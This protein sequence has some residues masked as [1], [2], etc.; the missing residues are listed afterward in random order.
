MREVSS[1]NAIKA[2]LAVLCLIT[3]S[4]APAATN[5]GAPKWTFTSI[6]FPDASVTVAYDINEDGDIVGFY[7]NSTGFH[8]YLLSEGSFTTIDFP[9][10]IQTRAY[11]INSKDYIVGLYEDSTGFHGFLLREGAFTS[12]D[13]PNSTYTEA[14]EINSRGDITGDYDDA[15]FKTRAFLLTK[16]GS[17][18]SLD[19]PFDFQAS[20]THGLTPNNKTIVG[21]WF[22]DEWVMHSLIL[23]GDEYITNDFPDSVTS[24][25]WRVNASGQMVGRYMDSAGKSHG[26]LYSK[27]THT[28]IDF[29][30]A[31]FTDACGINASG[32]IVGLYNSSDGRRHGFLLSKE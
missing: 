1:T 21:C 32:E 26:Y 7:R 8:G 30:D 2:W 4:L 19:T 20:L 15:D 27:G 12:I 10:A 25:N 29:P 16:D 22:D 17:F 18:I 5:A 13:F 28:S 24:M 23:K 3:L 31:T 14:W 9:D 6:D 11:G